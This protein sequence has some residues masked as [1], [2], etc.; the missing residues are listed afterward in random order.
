MS[1]LNLDMGSTLAY[2]S[3]SQ[4]VRIATESWVMENVFCANCGTLLSSFENNRPVA[5][6]YCSSCK[7]EYELKSKKSTMGKK[8]VDGAY[9]TM[10]DRLNSK[11]NPN[12][13]FLN[14]DIQ[15]FQVTNFIVIPKHFFTADIIEKRKALSPA[16]K[17]AGW[18][19]CNILFDTLPDA[20]KI[21]YVKNK[22]YESKDLILE[23]W[24]KTLFLKGIKSEEKGWLLDI[25]VAIEKIQR[26]TFSLKEVYQFEDYLRRKHP[27]NNNVQAKIRQ[28]LQY[29]RDKGYL[30]F[31]TRGNYELG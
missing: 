15:S 4:K 5:D 31:T 25:M 27:A 26:K 21:F 8:I 2:T 7:E 3:N 28:Q 29:L 12:F 16:A 14:Y 24:A 17:R 30:K 20:G 11:Q 18:V 13:F 1:I 9:T 22:K 23:N 6:F 19:G 10:I